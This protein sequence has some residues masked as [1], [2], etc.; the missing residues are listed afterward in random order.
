MAFR[1]SSPAGGSLLPF[2][3]GFAFRKGD[4]PSGAILNA[5]F[6]E[7]QITPR[8]VWPDG[9]LKFAVLSGRATLQPNVFR[10][11]K[12]QI[13]GTASSGVNV[14]TSDLRATGIT[15]S[16]SFGSYGT[17]S[18]TG[19]DWDTPF[20]SWIAGPEM[21]SWVFRK[22]L[23]TDAHLVAWLEV[24]CFKGGAV[25]VLPWI[26]N[27]YLGVA[28]PGERGGA[29][30]FTLG[31]TQRFS[32]T[33]SLL[34]HQRAVLAAGSTLAHWLGTDPQIVGGH[35]T[36]YMKSTRLVPN[37]A[38]VTPTSSANL[39]SL[40][41]TY[42]P[43]AQGNFSNSM[44]TTGYHGSIGLLP[45]WDAL[46][47]TS[48]A[49]ARAWRA[50]QINGY[51]AGRYGIHYRDE[52]TNRAPRM[53]S[54]PNL[55]LGEGS[56]I[57]DRGA[58]SKSTYT[59]AASGT[60]PP[61]FKSSHMPAIGYMAYL[62]TG[63]WYF[64]D[65]VQLLSSA[66]F[67]KQTDIVR[68][69]TQY[70]IDSA[71]GANQVRGMAWALRSLAHAAT[72]TP[73]SD[74]VMRAEYVNSINNNINRYHDYYVGNGNVGGHVAGADFD[75]PGQRQSPWED[76]FV[77]MAFGFLADQQLHSSAH[78]A[79]LDQFLAYKYQAVV[80]R[81]G[82]GTPGTYN[83]EYAAQYRLT[84]APVSG[85]DWAGKTGP[86]YADWGALAAGAG[87]PPNSG[88]NTLRGDSGA[89]PAELATGYWGNLHPAIAYAVD[90]G[91]SGAAL[92]YQR[93]TGASN[94][95]PSVFNNTPE[96][97]IVPRQ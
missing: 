43:L 44:G 32:Q 38:G 58:S 59:P 84:I 20:Q 40:A 81:L 79:K 31:G 91:A 66:L 54:Y 37:Y 8:N 72:V 1:L 34:N 35:D 2:A 25:E 87:I 82:P 24:R 63:R 71:S 21:S 55:V 78:Q 90:H 86:W 75:D 51:C 80:G 77:T 47:V 17:A 69:F 89:N 52:S 41:S 3:I 74:A 5:D 70:I 83:F 68:G 7:F 93:L 97:G 36:A 13:G 18:W 73:D 12:L 9:S 42:T 57:G 26:E 6:Q 10:T 4:A 61:V 22:P 85:P 49:D 60:A 92:A 88:T 27:G 94:Y 53:S 64:M 11:I 29:A 56:G 16:I 45:Q 95:Q 76:D 46:Y 15:A 19:A 23:G 65:E 67:L 14:A 96:W 48:S 33:L 50:V 39:A 62:V 30:T 28:A